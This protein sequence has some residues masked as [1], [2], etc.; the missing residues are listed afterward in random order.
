[1]RGLGRHHPRSSSTDAEQATAAVG[2]GAHDLPGSVDADHSADRD[3]PGIC[4]A[5]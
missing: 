3:I 4:T 2:R 1:V 5:R